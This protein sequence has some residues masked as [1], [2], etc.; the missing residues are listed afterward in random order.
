M[1]KN[2]LVFFG[3]VISMV[4]VAVSMPLT[5]RA[6][7][8]TFFDPNDG[9]GSTTIRV[10]AGNDQYVRQ[11]STYAR[12]Y[13]TA[14]SGSIRIA[15]SDWCNDSWD[16]YQ[17]GGGA[18][19]KE[20][21]AIITDFDISDHA[22]V[23]NYYGRNTDNGNNS[24]CGS[25]TFSSSNLDYDTDAKLWYIEIA[26]NYHS[27]T[28]GYHNGFTITASDMGFS[29]AVVVAQVGG[30]SGRDVAVEMVG[31]SPRYMT[32]LAKFGTD[33][34][35]TRPEVRTVSMYDLDN[36]SDNSGAQVGRTINVY[37]YEQHQLD[38]GSWTEWTPVTVWGPSNS[39]STRFIP[40]GGSSTTI[41]M[42]FMANPGSRYRV[43]MQDVYYNNTI[44]YSTPFDGVFYVNPCNGGESW[45]VT[46]ATTADM[47]FV[48]PGQTATWTHRLTKTG[49]G[50]GAI[51]YQIQQS[52]VPYGSAANFTTV[53]TGV[54][55][56]IT[57]SPVSVNYDRGF[58]ARPSDVGRTICQRIVWQPR[59]YNDTSS[60]QTESTTCVNVGVQ[61]TIRIL[62][63][64]L[65]VGSAFSTGTNLASSVYGTVTGSSASWV[66]Y[67]ITAP[68]TVG[69]IASQSGAV[70]GSASP[71]TAWSKETFANA[72]VLATCTT[73]FGCFS[74]QASLGKIPDVRAF[75][76]S[77]T[78]G[79]ALQYYD[80]GA[81]AVSTSTIPSIISGANLSNFTQSAAIATTGTITINS[82]ITYNNGPFGNGA[83]LPQLILIGGD[84]NI[85]DTV[86]RVDAWLIAT[87]TINTC[88]SVAQT[89]LRLTNCSNALTITGP[90]MSSQLLLNRTAYN[91]AQPQN[92]AETINLRGDAYV[93]AKHISEQS[94][95]WQTV[96]T[97]ELPPRY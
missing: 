60:D 8:T 14:N 66:E 39:P 65:R 32:Y 9:S 36:Q 80:R 97:T 59:A 87:G 41:G 58:L 23:H 68:H 85:A 13:F 74:T 47:T 93:W 86:Q 28:F 78:I 48:T 34:S 54:W 38:D 92:A 82:D 6:L 73:G 27:G 50:T 51:N 5:A 61:P 7:D 22:G 63:N 44:Q 55:N 2:P 53:A 62:G 90:V 33:C 81:T 89:A 83:Q 19:R 21:N 67:A 71:Q 12:A 64:D 25:V 18:S 46:G 84:I 72:N 42:S 35:L 70:N 30:G 49:N 56:P 15:G 3:A 57:S 31:S 94:G 26:A 43:E 37:M 77:G 79:S 20:N 17:S 16:W 1:S 40:T 10:L 75:V 24:G 88:S 69:A 29:R 95:R 11:A 76:A 96:Y 91:T 45:A 4:A 52:N